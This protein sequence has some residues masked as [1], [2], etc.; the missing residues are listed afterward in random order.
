MI[1][2]FIYYLKIAEK[3]DYLANFEGNLTSYDLLL[4]ASLNS[5][6]VLFILARFLLTRKSSAL[7]LV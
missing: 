6:L 5:K 3:L 1:Y 4:R 7:Q 2:E